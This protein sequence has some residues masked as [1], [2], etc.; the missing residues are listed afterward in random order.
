[1]TTTEVHCGSCALSIAERLATRWTCF[2]CGRFAR[3]EDLIPIGEIRVISA[4]AERR[5]KEPLQ[6]LVNDLS[7]A[8]EPDRQLECWIATLA[9][10]YIRLPPVL[11]GGPIRYGYMDGPGI[12]S[13]GQAWDML[14]PHFMSRFDD[15]MR[16]ASGETPRRFEFGT[17]AP[18]DSWA[19]AHLGDD[20]VAEAEACCNEPTA[21][22]VAILAAH[23]A[24]LDAQEQEEADAHAEQR[25]AT[26][27]DGSAL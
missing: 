10:G 11:E 25:L 24:R 23:I 14:V 2:A 22:V 9:K 26:Q 16:L 27:G 17:N 18:G 6:R 3:D 5:T 12:V 1:M 8:T 20:T 21:M 4:K 19:Y 7:A 15:A 13:P